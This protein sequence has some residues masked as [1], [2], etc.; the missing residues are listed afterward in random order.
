MNILW[1]F[2]CSWGLVPILDALLV[3]VLWWKD[4]KNL[5][6]FMCLCLY[7]CQDIIVFCLCLLWDF[8]FY[9]DSTPK[10][11]IVVDC[12]ETIGYYIALQRCLFFLD[13]FQHFFYGGFRLW[14]SWHLVC[15]FFPNGFQHFFY[16][17]LRLWW[18]WNLVYWSFPYGFQ[19][20]FLWWT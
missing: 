19:H 7:F 2:S 5:A 11:M 3:W 17:G 6:W 16:G 18:S 4:T 9:V 20:F 1:W 13:G 8:I 10:A 14:W 15:W 12:V